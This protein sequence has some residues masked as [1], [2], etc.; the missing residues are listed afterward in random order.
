MET[1][2]SCN[3]TDYLKQFGFFSQLTL[4][5]DLFLNWYRFAKYKYFVFDLECCHM[6]SNR[7]RLV[8]VLGRYLFAQRLALDFST[9]QLFDS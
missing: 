6:Q 8:S 5:K 7:L 1:Q 4:V 3:L 2:G 9:Y